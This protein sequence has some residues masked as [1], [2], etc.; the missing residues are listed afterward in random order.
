[1][2]KDKENPYA[3]LKQTNHEELFLFVHK[4]LSSFS[5]TDLS[6]QRCGSLFFLFQ[7]YIYIYIFWKKKR[8][9][10]LYY[11]SLLY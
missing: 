9:S 3:V 5:S 1:M 11:L 7:I 10:L 2:R 8:K 6:A 4:S